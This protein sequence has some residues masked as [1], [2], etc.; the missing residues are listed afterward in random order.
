VGNDHRDRVPHECAANHPLAHGTVLEAS[1]PELH[2]AWVEGPE[3]ASA[4]YSGQGVEVNNNL[5]RRTKSPTG[6]VDDHED[7]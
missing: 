1:V 3:G 5:N 7:F 2:Q 4:D 6:A